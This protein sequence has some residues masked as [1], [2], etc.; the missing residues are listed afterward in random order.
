[1]FNDSFYILN[2]THA[3]ST[4]FQAISNPFYEATDVI[5]AQI[6]QDNSTGNYASKYDTVQLNCM[7]D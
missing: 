4:S 7:L 1:M 5:P 2:L 3:F 6:P